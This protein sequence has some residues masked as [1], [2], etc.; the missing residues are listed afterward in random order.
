MARLTAGE[1]T[2]AILSKDAGPNGIDKIMMSGAVL[3]TNAASV[4]RHFTE[5]IPAANAEAARAGYAAVYSDTLLG[6]RHSGQILSA[7][8]PMMNIIN[9]AAKHADNNVDIRE[10]M[11][12]RLKTVGIRNR[13]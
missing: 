13:F 2:R 11:I 10:F 6:E 12:R 3:K 7:G 1:S 8:F 9:T 5:N 4:R